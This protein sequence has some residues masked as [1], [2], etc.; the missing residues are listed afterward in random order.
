MK[1]GFAISS[2]GLRLA[3]CLCAALWLAGCATQHVDWAGRVGHY[4]YEQAVLDMGPPDK[5]AKLADGTV[6]AEWL[7]NRGYT[8]VYGAPGPYGPFWGGTAS[9][10]TTPSMYMRLTFGPDSQLTA[11]KKTYR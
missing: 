11:W 1:T 9:A 10:Y 8:Y 6:V 3:A 7:L 2:P 5:Q 4:T